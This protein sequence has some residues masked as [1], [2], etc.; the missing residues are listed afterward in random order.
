MQDKLTLLAL[1]ETLRLYR[2][3]RV[4]IKEIPTLKMIYQP[5]SSLKKQ[6]ARLLKMIGALKTRNFSIEL[7]DG[8]SKVGGGALPLQDLPS[9]L[10]CLIPQKLSSQ[11]MERWLRAFDPP[12]IARLE[13]EK[14]LLDMRTVR[15]RDLKVMA[16]AIRA[17]AALDQV[18]GE[19]P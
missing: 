11:F 7:S 1:E 13:K 9:R 16:Q 14:V 2:D 5:Y 8:T 15:E 4:A 12:V 3:E 18:E 6:A 10:M 17:M 19:A